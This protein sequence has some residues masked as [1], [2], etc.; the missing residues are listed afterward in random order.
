M[1]EIS[2]YE[3]GFSFGHLHGHSNDEENELNCGGEM[4][5][6]SITN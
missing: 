6:F 2:I 3:N 5:E 1:V 4:L